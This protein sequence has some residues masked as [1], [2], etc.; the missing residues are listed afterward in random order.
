LHRL[1]GVDWGG[2]NLR[3]FLFDAD[4]RVAEARTSPPAPTANGAV[5]LAARSKVSAPG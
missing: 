1:I 3:A 2:S 5:W 4:G